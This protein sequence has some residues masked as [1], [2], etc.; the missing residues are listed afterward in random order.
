[1][2]K[3]KNS[4]LLAITLVIVLSLSAIP[5]FSVF[6]LDDV[7]APIDPQSWIM[8]ADQTWDD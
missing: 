4:R 6:A 2:K 3:M 1:M 8:N 5:S 7:P